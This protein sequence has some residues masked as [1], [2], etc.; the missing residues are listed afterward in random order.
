MSAGLDPDTGRD[1]LPLTRRLPF[2]QALPSGSW[3]P[4]VTMGAW[5]KVILKAL[6]R[7]NSRGTRGVLVAPVEARSGE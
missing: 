6:P 3:L 5:D 7:P 1:A 2:W 4:Q